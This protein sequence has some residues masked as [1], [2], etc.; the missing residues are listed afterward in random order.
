MNWEAV[1]WA[2]RHRVLVLIVFAA[3]VEAGEQV[4]ERGSAP[5][6][7]FRESLAISRVLPEWRADV[8]SIFAVRRVR[9]SAGRD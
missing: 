7:P 4:A 9:E 2:T 1:N 5:P 8:S 3:T 6:R